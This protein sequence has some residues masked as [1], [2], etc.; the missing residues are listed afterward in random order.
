MVP[1]GFLALRATRQTISA[2]PSGTSHI[3]KRGV[4][5]RRRRLRFGS[6]TQKLAGRLH[7]HPVLERNG[8]RYVNANVW[9]KGKAHIAGNVNTAKIRR[10]PVVTEMCVQYVLE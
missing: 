9:N 8:W 6:G 2:W 7:I 1:T 10:F 4:S 5:T 3:S